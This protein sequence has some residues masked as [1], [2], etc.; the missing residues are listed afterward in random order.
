MVS[1]DIVLWHMISCYTVSYRNVWY[2]IVIS[3][4]I[5][6]NTELYGLIPYRTI[7][8]L[9]VLFSVVVASNF[10]SK[11]LIHYFPS[12]RA[13][14]RQLH[15]L[16][17]QF[18]IVEIILLKKFQSLHYISNFDMV[19]YTVSNYMVSYSIVLYCI[20]PYNLVSYLHTQPKINLVS[21]TELYGV[22]LSYHIILCCI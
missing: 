2:H 4:R 9:T 14:T 8:Y 22:V 15:Q 18:T 19:S 13:F 6:L 20:L 21:Y 17:L 10:S 1:Y 3:N 11:N 7:V 5:T 12:S 16:L